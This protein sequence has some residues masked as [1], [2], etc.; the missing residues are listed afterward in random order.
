MYFKF[1]LEHKELL[2]G[3]NVSFCSL[4]DQWLQ[5]RISKGDQNW[6]NRDSVPLLQSKSKPYLVTKIVTYKTF[7]ATL[8][9]R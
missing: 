7:T 2:C 1:F 6:H 5:K 9:K 4:P 8:L 3:K